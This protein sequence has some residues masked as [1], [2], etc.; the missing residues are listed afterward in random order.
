HVVELRSRC[1]GKRASQSRTH[2]SFAAEVER[3]QEAENGAIA[4]IVEGDTAV[5]HGTFSGTSF[6]GAAIVV[7][8]VTNGRNRAAANSTDFAP[9]LVKNAFQPVASP[10]SRRRIG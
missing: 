4:R 6:H 2:G 10:P 1:P 7:R 8:R 3:R 9:A 5:M